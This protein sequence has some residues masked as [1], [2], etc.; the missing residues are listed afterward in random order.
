M[1][2][3]HC[4]L[5]VPAP[6]S[7]PSSVVVSGSVEA[8]YIVG[9]M[10]GGGGL[11]DMACSGEAQALFNRCPRKRNKRHLL[12]HHYVAMATHIARHSQQCMYLRPVLEYAVCTVLNRLYSAALPA[13]PDGLPSSPVIHTPITASNLSSRPRRLLVQKAYSHALGHVVL[14]HEHKTLRD[15]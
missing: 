5:P 3:A 7:A 8:S 1:V 4:D 6:G 12:L 9:G 11:N 15:S 14:Q 2:S 13:K 10:M